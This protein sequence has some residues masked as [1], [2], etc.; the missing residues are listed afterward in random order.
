MGL[1]V[2]C[3]RGAPQTAA[4]GGQPQGLCHRP[5]SAGHLQRRR[6]A[7]VSGAD[8]AQRAQEHLHHRPHR[9]GQ[10]RVDGQVHPPQPGGVPKRF[11]GRRRVAGANP[12]QVLQPHGRPHAPLLA[13]HAHPGPQGAGGALRLCAVLHP[14]SSDSG[15]Y[16][17][18]PGQTGRHRTHPGPD[19]HRQGQPPRS[20]AAGPGT[21][22]FRPHQRAPGRKPKPW[23][24]CSKA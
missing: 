10:V 24:N 21:C 5:V 3:R 1:C 19:G 18:G 7:G 14:E 16:A 11:R 20:D 6:P 13:G 17:D 4:R 22:P 15:G 9:R 23:E 2:R 12:G 8:P